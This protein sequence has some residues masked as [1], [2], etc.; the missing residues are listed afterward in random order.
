MPPSDINQEAVS[1]SDQD[2]SP[3]FCWDLIKIPGILAASCLVFLVLLS[4]SKFILSIEASPSP[5]HERPFRLIPIFLAQHSADGRVTYINERDL[6]IK[7]EDLSEKL[8]E[9]PWPDPKVEPNIDGVV[10]LRQPDEFTPRDVL[11]KDLNLDPVVAEQ[12]IITNKDFTR[13]NQPHKK[14]IFGLPNGEKAVWIQVRQISRMARSWNGLLYVIRDDLPVI[15]VNTNAE[16]EF[17]IKDI[18]GDGFKDVVRVTANSITAV[19]WEYFKW[20]PDVKSFRR[21]FQ[22]SDSFVYQFV[23]E[24]AK[25][26]MFAIAPFLLVFLLGMKFGIGW[27]RWLVRL[28]FPLNLLVVLTFT[29]FNIINIVLAGLIVLFQCF[30][31]WMTF[32][33]FK[34]RKSNTLKAG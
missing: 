16:T 31:T 14:E 19:H 11:L 8:V 5:H 18:D 7:A 34:R 2:V 20:T 17:A 27:M 32:R 15:L 24:E 6:G 29:L 10:I 26:F 3:A 9:L 12:A 4:I 28:Y 23:L 21:Y 30:C 33:R 22:A 25:V 1:D 13:L